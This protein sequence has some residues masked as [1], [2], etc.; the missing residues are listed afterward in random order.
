MPTRWW[1]S[2]VTE[3]NRIA[4]AQQCSIPPR[5]ARSKWK[6]PVEWVDNDRPR[7]LFFALSVLLGFR[8]KEA[9]FFSRICRISS[10]PIAA[11]KTER[12]PFH[13]GYFRNQLELRM[14]ASKLYY[15]NF[16]VD[17]GFLSSARLKLVVSFLAR[18]TTTET[19]CIVPL[20]PSHI[21]TSNK[22]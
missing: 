16:L 6:V 21:N 5:M 2:M 22:I 3:I 9:F 20:I 13:V 11:H 10:K 12:V 8:E 18:V 1:W 17:F 19:S 7:T 4:G 15:W 14:W